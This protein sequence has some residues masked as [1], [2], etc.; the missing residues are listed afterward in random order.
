MMEEKVRMADGSGVVR[1]GIEAGPL[2][3]KSGPGNKIYFEAEA[4]WRRRI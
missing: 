3:I 4:K 2:F 1:R